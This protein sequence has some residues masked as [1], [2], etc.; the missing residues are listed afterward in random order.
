[1]AHGCNATST[2][3]LRSRGAGRWPNRKL[4]LK[5][6]PGLVVGLRL[7]LWLGIREA[8]G[9]PVV[10]E[11]ITMN[12]K[13]SGVG[14]GNFTSGESQELMEGQESGGEDLSP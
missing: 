13:L 7:C 8:L 12:A 9:V 10:P 14:C 5:L 6:R 11:D 1:M 2:S 4:G 3:A